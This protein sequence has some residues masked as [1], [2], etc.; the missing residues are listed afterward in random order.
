M[1]VSV[2]SFLKRPMLMG[3]VA[4]AMLV[5]PSGVKADTSQSVTPLSMEMVAPGVY[6]HV[7]VHEDPSPGNQGDIS[8]IGF[9]IGTSGVAVI[10]SGDNPAL[11]HRLRAAIQGVTDLPIL[12]VINTHMHPDHVLGNVAFR[13]DDP[14]YIGHARLAAALADRESFYLNALKSQ[15]GATPAAGA[16]IIPPTRIVDIGAPVEID[17]GGRVLVLTA[18]PTAHTD[19]D[20]TV[21]DQLTG[22]LWA[23]DLIFIERIP[24]LD[25]SLLGWIKVLHGLRT[26][27][28]ARV[29]PG[30]GPAS[31]DWPQ[32]TF[33]ATRY[34]E[35]LAGDIRAILDRNGSL[36][37][38]A[39]S[40]GQGEKENWVLFEEYNG[41]NATAGYVELEW[42]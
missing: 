32:A 27:K 23:G 15:L 11:G 21:L 25:G 4:L 16:E 41:G 29:I 3:G 34:L 37:E 40:A 20:L 14:E 8:N 22:T 42:E 26:L 10:D 36:K 13:G 28:V 6:V 9:V 35:T 17:L 7:G 39:L 33:A 31:A 30:H 2:F 19:N 24:S 5:S 12:Y 38:A 1:S 18:Y